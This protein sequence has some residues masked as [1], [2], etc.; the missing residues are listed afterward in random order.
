[1]A[2]SGSSPPSSVDTK[3][4]SPEVAQPTPGDGQEIADK[5]KE[6]SEK[7]AFV[8]SDPIREDQVQNA[9]KFLSHPNVRGSPVIHRR[10]FL[11]RKGLT[12][13]E[14]NEAFRRVPDPSPSVTSGQSTSVGQDGQVTPSSVGQQNPAQTI[15]P[16]A[17][18]STGVVSVSPRQF[19]WS[20]ALLALGFLAISG[21][22]TLVIF[23][24]TI[25]PRFKSWIRGIVSDG[26]NDDPKSS[27]VK[28]SLE[29]EIAIA[30]KAAASAA[31]DVARTSQE[32]VFVQRKGSKQLEEFMSLFNAQ[33]K[34][35]R[36]MKAS[37][38]NIE[39]EKY[40]TGRIIHAEEEYYNGSLSR[41]KQ[42]ISNNGAEFGS[43]SVR[44]ISPQRTAD[45][46]HP[47]S[48]MEIMAMIQRGERPANIRDIDDSPPDPDQPISN[49]GLAPRAK[50][51]DAIQ[52]TNRSSFTSQSPFDSSSF[53]T[54]DG[55]FNS[56]SDN[57]EA[58]A[59][60]WQQKNTRITEIETGEHSSN[61]DLIDQPLKKKWVPPQPPPVVM[62]EAA[63]A[64]RQPKSSAAKD[65]SVSAELQSHDSE[66]DE[67]QRITKISEA[68]GQAEMNGAGSEI[69]ASDT[70]EEP[71]GS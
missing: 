28:P 37:V 7:S 18:S 69:S 48:Y 67:L 12:K 1:M 33:I 46:P 11:E 60:W 25:V 55:R 44:S 13:E 3:H 61:A 8:H 39:V 10:N 41:P 47:Q 71:I 36:S 21:A 17:S 45:P 23:K 57:N 19:H 62:P 65:Q 4:P 26:D 70:Q 22:G 34:E 63:M 43:R 54:R 49:P 24:K 20:H 42:R 15:Q 9:V 40:D 50:P 35:M 2:S 14:I 6:I 16:V 64:I 53:E 51:W 68:G 30:A 59:P 32:M 38:K 66:V 31:A 5:A 52:H 29:E 27:A 56:Q 58:P